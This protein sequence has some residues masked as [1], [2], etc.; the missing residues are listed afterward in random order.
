[1]RF[2]ILPS[3]TLVLPPLPVWPKGALPALQFDSGV[4]ML[5]R[6]SPSMGVRP[7]KDTIFLTIPASV[8]KPAVDWTLILLRECGVKYTDQS[9]DCENFCYELYQ[10]LCKMAAVA[11]LKAAPCVGE[12]D[13]A[14]YNDWAG[15]K[16]GGLHALCVLFTDLGPIVVESQNGQNIPLEA[17]P[18]RTSIT[19]AD[20][21]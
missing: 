11:G 16:A 10:T 4:A 6:H 14:A 5:R 13:V 15:V 8:V 17:Y 9:F 20:G 21:F 3:G 12:I 2:A 7:P 19:W 1:M 18:N